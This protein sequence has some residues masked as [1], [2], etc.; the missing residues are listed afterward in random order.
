MTGNIYI[1]GCIGTFLNEDGSIQEKGVE[2]LDVIMQVK[3]QPKA[4]FFNVY[5]NSPGGYVDTGFEIYD[6]LKSLGK[7]IN[8]IGQGMVASIAT[9][10][11]MAG[12]KRIL[13]PNTEFM[14]HLPGGGIEGN[15]DEVELYA[16]M[17][18]D[19]EKRIVKFYEETAGLS[20]SEILPLLRRETYLNADEAYKIGFATEKSIQPQAV[21]YFK[22]KQEPKKKT[23]SKKDKGFMAKIK[24]VLKS[25]EISNKIVFDVEQNELDFYELED[26]DTIEIGAKANYDGKPANGDYKVP[27]E[28]DPNIILTYQFENGELK[29]I[30]EPEAEQ[31]EEENTELLALQKENEALK[32]QIAEKETAVVDLTAEVTAL[33]ASNKA[34]KKAIAAIKM[35]ETGKAPEEI[36]KE[37]QNPIVDKASDVS[38]AVNNWKKNKQLKTRK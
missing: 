4:D 35:L 31:E 3:N 18:K 24:A 27:S 36:K 13:R 37:K 2:L 8:T 38:T 16:K 10:I 25:F 9:V 22:T 6:Y 28:E 1:N 29:A 20:E 19:I 23:M 30:V 33:K 11:F 26:T 17:L 34:H 21:A 14:I 32:A 5:I 12:D 15:S 7:P